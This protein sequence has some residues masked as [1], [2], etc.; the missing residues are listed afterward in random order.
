MI[1]TRPKVS[2]L[3]LNHNGRIHLVD[4]LPTLEAQT[5]PQELIEII[6]VD[7]GSTDDSIAFVRREHPRVRV[8][9]FE[10]NRGFAA[11]YNEAVRQCDTP[12][13]ALLNNDTRVEP[14]WLAELVGALQR[15]GA[16][17]AGARILDWAG[18]RID[19]GGGITSFIGHSWQRDA[20]LPATT[21]YREEPL[22]FACGGSMVIDRATFLEAGG[23]DESF[24]AYFEDVDL[25]WRL[26]LL[27]Q[28]VVFAPQAVTYHRTHGTSGRWAFSPRLR[29]Y[30]RNALAMIYK[31]YSE[32]T[33]TRVMPAALALSLA[34]GLAHLAI[35]SEP[36]ILRQRPP[37]VAYLGVRAI[38]HL[39]AVEDFGMD[40]PDLIEKRRRIQASR[41]RTDSELWPLFGDPFRL[42]ETGTR[43][44]AIA[45]TLIRDLR[46]DEL[47]PSAAEPQPK[48]EAHPR[49]S[50]E[51]QGSP[52][53]SRTNAALSE[54][55]GL[56]RWFYNEPSI[57]IIIPTALGAMHLPDCLAS[58]AAQRY[59][60]DR[61]EVIVVD[62]GS[63]SDPT[64]E[65]RRAYPG[66][67]VI[68]NATN[69]GFAA[70]NNVG[71]RAAVGDYLV[72]LNDDTRVHPDW[73]A[74]L[75]AVIRRHNAVCVGCRVLDWDGKLIDFC[76][77]SVN[78]EGR[79][80]QHH[81]GDPALR[82]P[83]R[84]APMLFACGAAMIVARD[85]FLE[86]GAWD[87]GT[88]A[89]YEDVELGWRLW[90]F[91]EE[92]WF[93]PRAIVYHKHHGTSGRWA[94]PPRLRLFQRNSLRM[95][96]THLEDETLA[97]VLS[98]ALIL[99]ADRALL[100]TA[101]HRGYDDRFRRKHARLWNSITRPISWL[102][103]RARPRR[104]L[105]LV[106]HALSQQGARK[107]LPLLV[108]LRRLGPL[109][110]VGAVGYVAKEFWAGSFGDRGSRDVYLLELGGQPASFD[111]HGERVPATAA[112]TL[113]GLRDFL[114]SL[115][116]VS[117]RRREIQGRRRRTDAE[118]L[119]R[120]GKWWLSP[121]ASP[122]QFDHND[123]QESLVDAFRVPSFGAQRS[124][125]RRS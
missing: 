70:A 100:G 86:A 17:C 96:Y 108:N 125:N 45:R 29:L 36:Y 74:E 110:F 69:L 113:L 67:R 14:D 18:D 121:V 19:F 99:A 57:S 95:I 30:E 123:I 15:H 6:V 32:E 38:A 66:V 10:G 105:W 91:G 42:H 61:C 93:A 75:V 22:L 111:A 13:V 78:F 58:I 55:Q 47:I 104:M 68:R 49:L 89:Y 87:E 60:S 25:G 116:D 77:G 101:V 9:A 43:Y 12:L 88:F 39:I 11:P 102:R 85:V 53:S 23:F 73:L 40:I 109:G 103:H 34:R 76:G 16:A 35:D 31:N 27:G 48:P 52:L 20:G 83:G 4:C 41:Q 65:A 54:K 50:G 72:F 94:E 98:P 97:R 28:T 64:N 118:I 3:V 124:T 122:R 24:F 120:F 2:V 71:A 21:P 84:E 59:P 115:P 92:V 90:L 5:Y 37:D 80:F 79:G 81:I 7:Q 51:P 33:L 63:A 8:I 44:E 46:I 1:T 82:T 112:A 26:N 107:H 119:E 56:E 106:R 117:A 114:E 62:N